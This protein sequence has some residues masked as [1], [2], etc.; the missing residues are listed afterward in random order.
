MRTEYQQIINAST[1][2][3]K[4]SI[5]AI[6]SILIG[7]RMRLDKFFSMFLDKFHRKMDPDKNDTPIWKLYKSKTNEYAELERTIRAADYYLRKP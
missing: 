2:G 4:K 3:D 5:V 7:E 1:Y 6:Q